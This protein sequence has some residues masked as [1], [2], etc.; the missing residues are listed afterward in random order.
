MQQSTTERNRAQPSTAQHTIQHNTAQHTIQNKDTMQHSITHHIKQNH[1]STFTH[2]RTCT[3]TS[4]KA[5]S[6]FLF[7]NLVS[8]V[9]YRRINIFLVLFYNILNDASSVGQEQTNRKCDILAFLTTI[10]MVHNCLVI[11]LFIFRYF[12]SI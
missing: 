3:C 10:S 5:S 7:S 12:V 1:M 11:Y 9:V 8:Y 2:I 4:Q 6:L